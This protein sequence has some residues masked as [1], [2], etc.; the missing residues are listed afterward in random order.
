MN[1]HQLLSSVF[2]Y[3]RERS[4]R[5]ESLLKYFTQIGL[6]AKLAPV[7]YNT[8]RPVNGLDEAVVQD[9]LDC[10]LLEQDG[11]HLRITNKNHLFFP[12]SVAMG[13]LVDLFM[14]PMDGLNGQFL[15]GGR[16]GFYPVIPTVEDGTILIAP[17]AEQAAKCLANGEPALSLFNDELP[18]QYVEWL[19]S[20]P[21]VAPVLSDDI[22]EDVLKR[23]TGTFSDS[24]IT[25][26]SS[27]GVSMMPQEVKQQVQFDP[28]DAK[29]L[30]F[31]R[32]SLSFELFG[33]IDTMDLAS[34]KVTIKASCLANPVVTVR[35]SVNLYAHGSSEQFILN[36]SERLL[37]PIEDVRLSIDHLVMQLEQY[38]Q[39]RTNEQNVSNVSELSAKERNMAE[40]YLRKADLMQRLSDDLGQIGLVGE[41][42][43]RLLGFLVS[44][45]RRLPQ[46]L[47][48]I[49]YG[50]TGSGKSSLL[51]AVVSVTPPQDVVEL[52]SSS[53][54]AFYH[55]AE[56]GLSHKLISIQDAY[57]LSGEVMYQLRELQ[58]KQRLIRSVT[59]KDKNGAFR[60][61]TSVVNGPV[62]VMVATTKRS[63]Y[64]DNANR[65]LELLIDES[66]AQDEQVLDR[67]RAI[68]S[69]SID[70]EAEAKMREHLCNVQRALQ[71]VTVRNPLANSLSFP[72]HVQHPRRS[73]ALY[74][75]LIS[76]ITFLHQFQRQREVSS[77]G[78]VAVLTQEEDVKWADM[79]FADILLRKADLLSQ[80]C[81]KFFQELKSWLSFDDKKTFTQREVCSAMRLHPQS[82]KR[83]IRELLSSGYLSIA[84]GNRYREG[85]SYQV[86]DEREYDQ[87]KEQLN[88][89]LSF[90][91]NTEDK[92]VSGSPVGQ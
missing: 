84:G 5:N 38:R 40:Q 75:G 81:R 18:H 2:N 63:L 73:N 90:G 52:T 29:H 23:V 70:L 86:S 42:S 48:F 34:M 62:A 11:E 21:A 50:K 35:D 87:L 68:A 76:A 74:L 79:L 27:D 53:E 88:G 28:T 83:S 43:N 25:P 60:T 32:G 15:L 22:S 30:R 17:N 10:G 13:Q 67:Q 65:S 39:I 24:G 64:T 33:G 1:T 36:V 37:L 80:A 91:K 58:S 3:L 46:P 20:H 54:K 71:N 6:D 56:Q 78:Q 55:M 66:P 41:V 57:G 14:V 26:F 77:S 16:T 31:Q 45:S 61:T 82:V 51:D 89:F 85:Y 7:A 4:L 69:G 44:V 9:G 47:N 59:I 8:G 12:L 49:S 92:W 19:S 72:L